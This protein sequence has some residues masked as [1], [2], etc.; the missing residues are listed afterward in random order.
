MMLPLVT[1]IIPTYN[2]AIYINTAIDSIL[3]QDYPKDRIEIIVIDDGSTDNTKVSLFDYIKQG[4]V[5]YY[6][7]NNKGKASATYNGIQISTGKYLFNLDADDVFLPNK[8][9]TVVDIF[10][11]DVSIVHVGSPAMRIYGNETKLHE[12]EVFPGLIT[13]RPIEG[14]WLLQYFLENNILFGGGSTYVGRGDVLR[15]LKIPANVDMYI[16]EFLIYAILPYGKSYFIRESLSAW[17]HHDFNY[18]ASQNTIEKRKTKSQRILASASGILEYLSV[19]NFD[20]EII[21]IYKLKYEVLKTSTKESFNEKTIYDIL[22][23]IKF[24][25]YSEISIVVLK[26]YYTFNRLVPMCIYNIVKRYL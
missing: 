10:E 17:R 14:K 15:E 23:F 16:D 6:Y 22:E 8:I 19:N 2:Y 7:Q 13:N 18:S 11:N 21:K 25:V 20:N 3:N 24:L 9:S 1:V 12:Y 26:K 5:K 4:Y